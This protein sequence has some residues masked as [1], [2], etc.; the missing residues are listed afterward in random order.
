MVSI[1][2][3]RLGKKYGDRLDGE[4]KQYMD[5][6]TEGASR[7]RELI[8]DLL[9]YSRVDSPG[10]EFSKVD[11]NVALSNALKNLNASITT[12]HATINADPLP[13]VMADGTQ[14]TELLQN[15]ISNAVKYHGERP[16]E[17]KVTCSEKRGEY[18]IAVRDNGIG[19]ASQYQ[20][21]IFQ[22]FQRL[23]S[24]RSMREQA[25]GSPYR[26]RSIERHGGRIW[27]ESDGKNG[28][29][30]YFTISKVSGGEKLDE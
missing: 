20:E 19:V 15:L 21:K 10:K 12:N 4:A 3:G 11:M 22:M 2:L 28:S 18:Q 25:S 7:M 9:T 14:V 5:Y 8:N 23:H 13:T 6:A 17:I 27:V 30:F 26:R 16:P 24:R 29:T 1:S